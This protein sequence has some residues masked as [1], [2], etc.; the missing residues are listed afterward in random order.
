VA[1]PITKNF[2]DWLGGLNYL[3][4]LLTAVAEQ[5]TGALEP[6]LV[7]PSRRPEGAIDGFPEELEVVETALLDMPK[8]AWAVRTAL[9]RTTRRDIALERLLRNRQIDLLSHHEPLGRGAE[10]PALS[11]VPDAQHRRMPELFSA[12]ELA[13]RDRSLRLMDRGSAGIVVSSHA[14][15]GDLKALMPAAAPRIHVLRFVS[16]PSRAPGHDEIRALLDRHSLERYL[17]LPNQLWV[18]KN[19][20]VVIEALGLLRSRG[21]PLT[22]VATGDTVD[23]RN[24]GLAH[25]LAQRAEELG[26]TGDFKLLGRVPYTE[27]GALMSGAVGLMNPSL[28]EGWS[29]TVEEGR[30]LGKRMVLSDID[31]HREQDPP[32]A[33]YVDPHDPAGFAAALD[34]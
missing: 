18:H 24:P 13:A 32:A 7:V 11:W 17:Y 3:R 31:V 2:F 8:P 16:N 27:V 26:V 9:T 12:R 22:V 21:R 6:V 10:I 23:P 20:R 29:T 5:G 25:E 1:V 15:S 33:A 34:D 28:F 19:H 30:A 14:A 4:T